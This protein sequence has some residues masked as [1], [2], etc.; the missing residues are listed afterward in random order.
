MKKP[1]PKK[2]TND[3]IIEAVFEV[4]FQNDASMTYE[5]LSGSTATREKWASFRQ[6]KDPL[7]EIPETIR[8]TQKELRY[9]PLIELVSQDGATSIRIG[10]QVLAYSRRGIYPGWDENFGPE[11]EDVINHLFDKLPEIKVT[12]LGLRYINALRSDLHE[13]SNIDDI[14]IDISVAGKQIS[15]G[16][17]INFKT[18]VDDEFETMQRLAS[19]DIAVGAIPENASII[20]DIDVYTP[21]GFSTRDSVKVQSWVVEA[22]EKEKCCFFDVL[23]EETTDRLREDQ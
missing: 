3:A 12:R 23:G 2:L 22:H 15:N 9:K 14:A 10:P 16:W 5:I 19:A 8:R 1:L 20:V 11:L 7:G 18:G 21:D 6:I 4:R 13:I 17:N